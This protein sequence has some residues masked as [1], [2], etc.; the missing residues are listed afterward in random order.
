M[1]VCIDI[2]PAIAQRAGVGRYTRALAERVGEFR[3]ADSV[4]LFYFD[5][6]RRGAPFPTPGA[7]QTAV[8][9]CPGR[10][11]QKTW[12]VLDWPPFDWFAGRAD[13]Y[14]F[15]NF[16][17]PPL[18]AGRTVV[19]IH[20]ASFLR[21]PEFAERRNLAYLRARIA[22]TVR[23]A[24][25]IITDSE[26]SARELEELLAADRGRIFT[27]HLGVGIQAPSAAH[28][29]DFRRRFKLERPYLLTVGTLEPR[30]NLEFLVGVFERLRAFD[31]ELVIAGMRGWKYEPILRRLQTSSR[32]AAIR[33]LEYLPEAELA[34]L[35]GGAEIFV[36]PSVYEGFGLPPLEAMR[37]GVPV[38]AA[39][40]GALP[41]TLGAGARL[42]PGF[43]AES[44]AEEVRRLLA[45]AASRQTLID[46]GRRH[47]AN[48]TWSETARKTWEIY[49]KAAV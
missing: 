3:G 7:E 30:K 14:H 24:D 26:F 38:L 11:A 2:Q 45:D 4:R 5:F 40:A 49:R 9:W 22:A 12:K 25:A 36:F 33:Y 8:H 6:Q 44:W 20:D 35:Y 41:E 13:L 47:A 21:H 48:Y 28:V 16:I 1:K 37:C 27:I 31:G 17:I 32:A 34:A 15:P 10:W 39:S 23:Q 18:T 42:V 19:T 46:S 29:A 43:D